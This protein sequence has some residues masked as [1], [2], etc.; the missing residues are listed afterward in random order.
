M[1]FNNFKLNIELVPNTAWNASIYQLC[2]KTGQEDKWKAI[3]NELFKTEGRKCWI[4]GETN[5]QLEAHEF[6]N[7]DEKTKIQK[8]AAI[9]HLCTLCHKIKHVGLFG[10]TQKGEEIL[11]QQGLTLNDLIQH[12]CK[13]NN[14]TEQ[15]FKEHEKQ[16]FEIWNKR[17]EYNWKQD[18]G[19]YKEL[20]KGETNGQ[21]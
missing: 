5:K 6:W 14:C 15:E 12:F 13:V 19:K 4:C 16:A 2:K 10:H 7:Y 17:N 21:I 20:F 3:K 8:L 9:H 1:T 11:K 18:F